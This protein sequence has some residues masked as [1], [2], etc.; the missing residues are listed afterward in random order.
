[1]APPTPRRQVAYSVQA[2]ND[3]AAIWDCHANPYLDFLKN[4]IIML[5]ESKILGRQL[6]GNLSRSYLLMRRKSRG[7]GHIAVY[8]IAENAIIILHVF[9]SAQD[10]QEQQ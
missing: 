8:E 9:H 10:W 7:H 2:E 5:A 3:L 4:R 1:M 6:P